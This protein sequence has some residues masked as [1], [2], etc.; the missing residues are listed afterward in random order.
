METKPS[1]LGLKFSHLKIEPWL[2]HVDLKPANMCQGSLGGRS[3][4][5][6]LKKCSLFGI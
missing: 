1:C 4:N 6:L 3:N 5:R 2:S